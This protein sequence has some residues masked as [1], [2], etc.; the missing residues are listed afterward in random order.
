MIFA[1]PFRHRSR[2]RR[3]A[4]LKMSLFVFIGGLSGTAR[5]TAVELGELGLT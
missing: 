2:P 1:I 5:F 3:G 4:W